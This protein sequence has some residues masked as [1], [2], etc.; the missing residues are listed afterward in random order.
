MRSRRLPLALAAAGTATITVL[1]VATGGASAAAG[2]WSQVP[3]PDPDVQFTNLQAIDAFADNDAWA[4]GFVTP[5]Q[6]APTRPVSLRWNG[7]TWSS[8]AVPIGPAL[9][10]RRS[11]SVSRMAFS[12][13]CQVLFFMSIESGKNQMPLVR[14]VGYQC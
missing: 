11:S 5:T 14:E 13:T 12:S 2:A 1:V 9:M 6:V 8:V 7:T 4:V 10:S 3:A